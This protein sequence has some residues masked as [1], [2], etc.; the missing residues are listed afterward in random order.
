[1]ATSEKLSL[2]LSKARSL[3]RRFERDMSD[4][5]DQLGGVLNGER[6]ELNLI[7]L[8]QQFTQCFNRTET[9]TLIF[10]LGLSGQIGQ[11]TLQDVHRELIGW[12]T[13][14]NDMP[15]LLDYL[16]KNRPNVDWPC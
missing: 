9:A 12:F 7:A 16:A 8:R 4:A 1:M 3:L 11:G 5:L 10:D 13:R 14:R 6:E 15:R 2:E